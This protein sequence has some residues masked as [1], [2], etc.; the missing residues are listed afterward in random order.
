MEQRIGNQERKYFIQ[1]L[2]PDIF[3]VFLD[4]F[5]VDSAAGVPVGFVVLH[6]DPQRTASNVF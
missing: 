4:T 3:V 1:S 2:F 5:Q 6:G